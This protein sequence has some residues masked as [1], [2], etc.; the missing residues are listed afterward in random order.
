MAYT[1]NFLRPATGATVP[2]A[3]QSANV[4]TVVVQVFPGNSADAQLNITHNLGIPTGDISQ[5]FPLIDRQSIDSL[6][7]GSGYYTVSNGPNITVMNRTGTTAGVDSQA[8][9]QIAIE[10][11]HTIV[12]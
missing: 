3:A 5:G 6:A 8:Q 4:N 7:G 12:Q 2:T 9:L 1:V 10:R 11:P